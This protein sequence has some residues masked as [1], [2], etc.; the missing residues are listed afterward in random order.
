MYLVFKSV[1]CVYLMSAGNRF[2]EGKGQN[3]KIKLLK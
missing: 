2:E 1:K 3:W